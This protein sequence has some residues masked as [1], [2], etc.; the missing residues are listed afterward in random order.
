MNST[1]LQATLERVLAILTMHHVGAACGISAHA[2]A[3]AAGVPE[4]SVRHAVEAAR[5]AGHGICAHPATGYFMPASASEIVSGALQDNKRAVIVG[6][7][8]FG[9]GS[10]PPNG[11]SSTTWCLS[12]V[13]SRRL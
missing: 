7:R 10:V 9:K 8:T 4:R 13:Q 1:H 12:V 11:A 5:A 2:L 3:Q 6:E